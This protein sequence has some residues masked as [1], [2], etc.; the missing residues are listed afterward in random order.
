M[1]GHYYP[2][3]L[4]RWTMPSILDVPGLAST[5]PAFRAALWRMASDRSWDV[6][7]IAT[8]MS[9]E[10]GFKPGAKN[11]NAT[12]SGLIQFIDSTARSLGIAGG[13]AEVRRMSDIEQLPYVAKYYERAGAKSSWRPVD[14]YLAG[15]GN[16]IGAP[17]SF[18][19]ARAGENKYELNKALD[20]N[21]D[22]EIRVSDLESL[23]AAVA[24]RA[25]GRRIE[26]NPSA[27]PGAKGGMI[28]F[29]V[30]ATLAGVLFFKS[31]K[32]KRTS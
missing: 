20:R 18:V 19:L 24:S 17:S 9:I 22:G 12:A 23:M 26:V 3:H 31:M 30:L 13:A 32:G 15:W 2:I 25:G 10:S 29:G 5:S 1:L 11:P 16:G 8:V 28:G 27:A 21:G 6:D 7:A 4:A 14:F